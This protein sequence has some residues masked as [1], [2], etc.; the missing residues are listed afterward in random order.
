MGVMV[1]SGVS[2]GVTGAVASK[3]TPRLLAEVRRRLRLK[4]YS[5]R[6]EQAYVAWIRR[7]ILFH[8]KRHPREMSGDEVERFLTDR[9]RA[10]R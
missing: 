4:H 1:Y 3:P 9:A 2:G 10:S 6:T 5:L 7:F 8:G